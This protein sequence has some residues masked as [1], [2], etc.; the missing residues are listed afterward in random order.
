MAGK[1]KSVNSSK[2]KD[3]FIDDES[4]SK[5][6]ISGLNKSLN[7]LSSNY[8]K[9]FG[10][11]ID[12]LTVDNDLNVVGLIINKNISTD[13]EGNITIQ[14]NDDKKHGSLNLNFEHGLE[15][16]KIKNKS[17][18]ESFKELSSTTINSLNYDSKHKSKEFIFKIS[19]INGVISS[20]ARE[21]KEND[22][23]NLNK[24]KI[25]GLIEDLE[26]ISSEY[27]LTSNFKTSKIENDKKFVTGNELSVW[28]GTD[29]ENKNK[30]Y[31]SL[32]NHTHVIDCT[33][34]I[35]DGMID[36]VKVDSI[37]K[38]LVIKWNTES[39]KDETR[40]DLSSL[41]NIYKKGFGIDIDSEFVIKI[42]DNIV[43]S[44]DEF[45][46]V[47]DYT[48]VLKITTIPSL[49]NKVD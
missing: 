24:D 14:G 38:Q 5:S 7:D 45:N 34:F 16:I 2:L 29:S 31:I 10:D 22:I 3:D 25:T 30:I 41:A 49:S 19:Q 12:S 4:I 21:L 6:K 15:D 36:T 44:H 40:I 28:R 1:I 17:L 37:N 35:K 20:D 43:V 27:L 39:G 13:T 42:D 33:D 8:I 48:D 47:K 18:N 11:N 26:N 23:T 9:K 32:D 46:P